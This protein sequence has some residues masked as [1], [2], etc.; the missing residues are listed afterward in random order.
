VVGQFFVQDR[1]T[2]AIRTRSSKEAER[3]VHALQPTAGKQQVMDMARPVHAAR[4]V[5]R[6]L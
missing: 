1:R 4:R 3:H 2:P 5:A 6:N